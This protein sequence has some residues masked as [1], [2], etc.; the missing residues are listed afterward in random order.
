MFD[1]LRRVQIDRGFGEEKVLVAVGKIDAIGLFVA[2]AECRPAVQGEAIAG[3][4]NSGG[5]GNTDEAVNRLRL[6]VEA[7][8]GDAVGDDFNL[9]GSRQRE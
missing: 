5:V 6:A 3:V 4:Q 2:I 8:I 1:N 9:S 7:G